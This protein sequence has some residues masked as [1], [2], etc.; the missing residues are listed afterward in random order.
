MNISGAEKVMHC[1]PGRLSGPERALLRR[2]HHFTQ[3]RL[4]SAQAAVSDVNGDAAS[5]RRTQD[6]VHRFIRDCYDGLDGLAQEVNLCM[7]HLYPA[8]GLYPPRSMTRQC[9]LYMVR[10]ILRENP[11]TS[12]HPVTSHL[13]RHTREPGDDEYERLSFLYNLTIFVPVPLLEEGGKLPGDGDLPAE[14]QPFAR[15]RQIRPCPVRR[16]LKEMLEWTEGFADNTY[17]L[18]ADALADESARET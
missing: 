8:A 1:A 9:G 6:S 3:Q 5:V 11:D 2:L 14:L 13:W 12:L 17:G 10:K 7:H 18:L 16:G 15:D 4:E